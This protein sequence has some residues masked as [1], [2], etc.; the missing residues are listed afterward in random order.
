L[1]VYA[2]SEVEVLSEDLEEE[3]SDFDD[4]PG[5]EGFDDL[6]I[7]QLATPPRTA[8]LPVY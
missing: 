4:D 8:D 5:M 2:G 1:W 3:E 7:P 6:D